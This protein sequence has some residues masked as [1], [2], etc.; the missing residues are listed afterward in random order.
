MLLSMRHVRALGID[1]NA[2]AKR[3]RHIDVQYL[4]LQEAQREGR[5]TVS[6]VHT[7]QDPVDFFAKSATEEKML[8][9]VALLNSRY[10]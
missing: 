6:K 10:I 7:D 2:H 3:L 1:L 9:H 4:W 5:V 8:H